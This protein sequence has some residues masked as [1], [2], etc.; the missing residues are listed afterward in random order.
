MTYIAAN[1]TSDGVSKVIYQSKDGTSTKTFDT[2]D[3]LARLLTSSPIRA[4]PTE[5]DQPQTASAR[6]RSAA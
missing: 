6:Q 4:S 2:L 1:D 3:W 5:A